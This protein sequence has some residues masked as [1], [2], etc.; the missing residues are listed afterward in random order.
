MCLAPPPEFRR[1]LEG[2]NALCN[3]DSAISFAAMLRQDN[4]LI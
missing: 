4:G 2:V 3:A 1:V